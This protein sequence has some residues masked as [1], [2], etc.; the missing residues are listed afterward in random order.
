MDGGLYYGGVTKDES[1]DVKDPGP[2]CVGI[3][4]IQVS[5]RIT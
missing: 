3:Q 1:L 4:P 5:L 2:T